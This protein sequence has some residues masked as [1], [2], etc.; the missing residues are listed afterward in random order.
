MLYL[1]TPKQ[2]LRIFSGSK[3]NVLSFKDEDLKKNQRLHKE[4]TG[5][6]NVQCNRSFVFFLFGF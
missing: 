2:D 1:L 3:N 5:I 4:I 6:S